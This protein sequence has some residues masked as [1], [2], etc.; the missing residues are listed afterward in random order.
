MMAKPMNTPTT[1][2]TTRTLRRAS[3][4]LAAMLVLLVTAVPAAAQN[5][6]DDGVLPGPQN[7]GSGT[8]DSQSTA[9]ASTFAG[10]M[11]GQQPVS[12]ELTPSYSMAT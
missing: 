9:M 6:D 10:L 3:T 1:Q 8:P 12:V 5:N 4:P 7:F 2:R 11:L